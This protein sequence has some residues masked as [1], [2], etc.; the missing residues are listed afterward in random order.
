MVFIGAAASTVG[1]DIDCGPPR[2][3]NGTYAVFA[4]IMTY[5]GTNLEEFPSY[6]SPANGWRE[7]TIAWPS[8]YSAD[9]DVQIDDTAY[10]AHGEWDALVCGNFTLSLSGPYV[11]GQGSSHEFEAEGDFAVFGTQIEGR[12]DYSEIWTTADG[13]ETG[14][15]TTDGQIAG[16]RI[17]ESD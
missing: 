3:V 6:G 9:V 5:D 11:S 13:E 15:F 7:W 16:S 14:T 12:W 4:N 8:S 2:Q 10:V 1:C 17:E